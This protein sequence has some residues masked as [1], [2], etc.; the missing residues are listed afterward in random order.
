METGSA[1]S[2]S[3]PDVSADSSKN[4]SAFSPW[5]FSAI[6]LTLLTGDHRLFHR[7]RRASPL[8]NIG[9]GMTRMRKGDYDH[10]IP[11]RWAAGSPP[12]VAE[13]ANELARTLSR[14]SHDNRTLL[15]KI[16]SLQ[17]D[18]RRDIARDLHD[19]L[20]PAAVRH[21]RQC[22][23]AAGSR[24]ARAGR[25]RRHRAGHPAIGRGAAAGQPPRA[26]PAAAALHRGAGPREEHPDPAA[27]C[28]YAG[29]RDQADLPHRSAAERRRRPARRRPS[30]A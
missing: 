16:V 13:E 22:C 30:I 24:S 9:E 28:A 15:R 27:E 3:S 1:T 5:R 7:R 21:P 12:R 11:R 4:G 10:P 20:G 29:A 26:R 2:S 6:A 14:L 25:S 23:R 8:R 17:D 18:E 19:E